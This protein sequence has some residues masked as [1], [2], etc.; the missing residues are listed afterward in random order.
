MSDCNEYV[1]RTCQLGYTCDSDGDVGDCIINAEIEPE[2]LKKRYE[3]WKNYTPPR[4]T[5][6]PEHVKPL[7]NYGV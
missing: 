6:P 1:G 3:K 7:E 4:N 5:E 2:N